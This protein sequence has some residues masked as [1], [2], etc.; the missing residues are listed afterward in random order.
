MYILNQFARTLHTKHTL[1]WNLKSYNTFSANISIAKG[2]SSAWTFRFSDIVEIQGE[3]ESATEKIIF[4]STQ[5]SGSINDNKTVYT[6]VE[7]PLSM[8]RT[9]LDD[10]NLI[11]EIPNIILND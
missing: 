6:L 8:H 1:I 11:S 5:M 7:D 9:A 10:T 4:D 2:L 3:I